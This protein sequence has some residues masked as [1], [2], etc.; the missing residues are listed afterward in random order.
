MEYAI[1]AAKRDRNG[2]SVLFTDLDGFK[3]INDQYG[4]RAGDMLL[5]EIAH[6]LLARCRDSDTVARYGGDEF[7]VLLRNSVDIEVVSAVAS[8][9]IDQVAKPVV[10]DNVAH[11]VRA[12]VGIAISRSCPRCANAI[13][14]GRSGD[15]RRKKSR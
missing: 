6:R 8:A 4:H 7:I 11:E 2:F 14:D 3:P 9:L 10:I 5:K 1:A 15:V 12:S 13:E